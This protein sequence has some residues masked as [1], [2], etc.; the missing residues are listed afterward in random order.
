MGRFHLQTGGVLPSASQN[1]ILT[2]PQINM[3]HLSEEPKSLLDAYKIIPRNKIRFNKRNNYPLNEMEKLETY[4]LEYGLIEDIV[5]V[6]S[7]D[8]DIYI[9]ESGHRRTTALDNLIERYK[10]W[11]GEPNDDHYVL[12][13]KNVKKYENGYVCKVIERITDTIDY[14]SMDDV[15]TDSIIDS[16]IRLILANEGSRTI[17]PAVKAANVQRLS[18]LLERKNKGKHRSEM[19]NINER[20]ATELGITPRQVIKYKQVNNLIPELKQLFENDKISLSDSSN[21]S[22]LSP[23]VQKDIYQVILSGKKASAQKIDELKRSNRLLKTRIDAISE[24]DEEQ[25]VK[26]ILSEIQKHIRELNLL[27]QEFLALSNNTE[28]YT[29]KRQLPPNDIK[30]KLQQ[31]ISLL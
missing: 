15:L 10:D 22:K 1:T 9:I 26:N 23:E 16:E 6:Y 31:L 3:Q 5:V 8:E 28:D 13:V 29:D 19:I 11:S 4:I 27:L 20:I 25:C 21:F 24:T 18:N 17:S 12:Y 2:T 7:E 14:D 30:E